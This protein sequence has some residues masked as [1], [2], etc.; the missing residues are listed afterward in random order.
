MMKSQI[1]A[2]LNTINANLSKYF[3]IVCQVLTEQDIMEIEKFTTN[4]RRIRKWA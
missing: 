4:L 2:H 3:K 1:K